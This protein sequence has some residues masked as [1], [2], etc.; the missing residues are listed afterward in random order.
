MA[1]FVLS[2]LLLS[3][4]L[5]S[6]KVVN[7]TMYVLF[8]T[9]SCQD[10]GLPAM[11]TDAIRLPLFLQLLI[12]PPLFAKMLKTL[13]FVPPVVPPCE[14]L[15]HMAFSRFLSEPGTRDSLYITFGFASFSKNQKLFIS[16]SIVPL[17][18]EVVK[19]PCFM[20]VLGWNNR[21]EQPEQSPYFW[22][23]LFHL[24]KAL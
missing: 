15:Q 19:K 22:C 11:W 17:R 14:P 9:T 23:A 1:S 2:M 16:C 10:G 7:L 24:R 13:C 21:P 6:R 18:E 8:I 20:R 12:F 5:T 4:G 3:I